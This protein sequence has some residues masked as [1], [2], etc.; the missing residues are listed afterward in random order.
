MGRFSVGVGVGVGDD[1]GRAR[2]AGS[3]FLLA[4]DIRFASRERARIGQFEVSASVIPGGG[5]PVPKERLD[6]T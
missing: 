4:T 5:A 1:S 3:E 6:K 2:G